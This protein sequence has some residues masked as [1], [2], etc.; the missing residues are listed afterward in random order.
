VSFLCNFFEWLH[1]RLFG[2]IPVARRLADKQIVSQ[3]A[4]LADIL[5]SS[6]FK[7]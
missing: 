7:L 1:C 6:H 2:F 3:T 4:I 5:K